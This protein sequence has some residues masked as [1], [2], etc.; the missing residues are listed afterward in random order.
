MNKSEAMKTIAIIGA[1]FCGATL[2]ARLLRQPPATPLRVVLINRSGPMAR[3]VAY[4][5]RT[6][7]QVLNVPVGRMD[8]LS[9]R[10]DG[11][12]R[13]VRQRIADAAPGSFVAR[14]LYGDYLEQLLRDA[15]RDAPAGASLRTV[16]GGVAALRPRADGEGARLTLDDGS[17]LDA[18]RVVL[19]VGNYA[20]LDPPIAA[21]QRR[22]YASR[23]YIRDP[24]APGAL[25]RVAPEQ[26]VLVIGSG[27]TMLDILLELRERGH[28]APIHAISRRGLAPQAHR[29]L[30][31]PPH[32]DESLLHAMLSEPTARNYLSLVRGAAARH[33]RG[34]GDW[35]DIVGGLRAR[36]PE[37][38]QALPLPERRRFL[39]RLRPFWEVHRHR[40]A[41]QLG[42][43]LRAELASGSLRLLA[44]RAIAYR[45]TDDGVEATLQPRG[46]GEALRLQVGAVI[47]CTGPRG[48]VR[49]LDE[50][51]LDSLQADGLLVPDALGLGF[52]LDE[53]YALRDSAGVASRWLHYVGPFLKGR[54]WEA[55]AVP[56]LRV[57][58]ARLAE[59]LSLDCGDETRLRQP[60]QPASA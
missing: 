51:L 42:E 46:G 1:G 30:D 56:E 37:L 13:Y 16:V 15:E 39:Q 35:R 45:E 57:H 2:A 20:P 14:S 59:A 58:V 9:E 10:G 5:S 29:A 33:A 3:G 8:A 21:A 50:P 49:R 32:Y 52:E 48:D 38:W 44:G 22:F 25:A 28:R 24:W 43:R 6:A 41:P 17:V 26:P 36:T 47:N 54:Y 53:R 18:D 4:G 60:A 23:R 27:L 31:N 55:T 7:T 19:C 40:C 12:Y 11:F 34:G